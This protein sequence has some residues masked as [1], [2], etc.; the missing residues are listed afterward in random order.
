M[1][2]KKDRAPKRPATDVFASKMENA[3]GTYLTLEAKVESLARHRALKGEDGAKIADVFNRFLD[4]MASELAGHSV[5]PGSV[6]PEKAVP[7]LK[8]F[9]S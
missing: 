3:Y 2:S 7:S 5:T 4:R 9:V 6:E 1:P 8:E